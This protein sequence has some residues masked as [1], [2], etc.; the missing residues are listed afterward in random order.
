MHSNKRATV[1]RNVKEISQDD[2]QPKK[3]EEKLKKRVHSVSTPRPFFQQ[4]TTADIYSRQNSALKAPKKSTQSLKTNVSP[5]KDLQKTSPSVTQLKSNK[6][7][8]TPFKNKMDTRTPRNLKSVSNVTVNSPIV[9]RKLTTDYV[10]TPRT[11]KEV[12]NK[13][14]L[15]KVSKSREVLKREVNTKKAER[16]RTHTR[17]LEEGEVKVLTPEN[18]DNNTGM[19]NLSK[20]LSAQ[21]KAFYVDLEGEKSKEQN[22]ETSDEDIS[23]EDDFESYE[24]DFDSYHSSG[25]SAEEQ[26]SEKE[27]I[28]KEENMLDSGT[29]EMRGRSATSAEP[30]KFILEDSDKKTSLTDEG[31][32]D[33]SSSSTVSSMK[34]VHVEVLERPLFIDFTKSKENRRKRR[35]F[36]KLKQRANDIL[37]MVTLHEMSFS[38]FEMKPI[39]YDLYM[40][41][42]GRSNYTQVVVQTFDDGITV[43]VQTEEIEYG[44]KWTQHPVEFSKETI[45]VTDASNSKHNDDIEQTINDVINFDNR[46]RYVR[47][48]DS[49]KTNPLRIY[50][51]QKDGAG[52]DRMLP[53]ETYLS[54]TKRTE[55]NAGKLRKF[56]KKVGHRISN[57][58]SENAGY[59]VTSLKATSKYPFSKEFLTISSKNVTNQE[60]NYLKHKKITGVV[61]SETKSSLVLT[62]HCKTGEKACILCLWDLNVAILKPV[63]KL[64]A[65]EV[66]ERGVF[67]GDVDG[68]FV[69]ALKD[70]TVHLWDL[71]EQPTVSDFDTREVPNENELNVSGLKDQNERSEQMLRACAFTS[72]ASNMNGVTDVDS[73]VG[74]EFVTGNTVTMENGNK[75]VGQICTLLKR[76]Y[77]I[78]YSIIQEK[79]KNITADLGKA[80]WSKMRLEKHQTVVLSDY[81]IPTSDITS[82]VNF[83]LDTAK[84]KLLL[85]RRVMDVRAFSRPK[86]AITVDKPSSVAS[87][88]RFA[89][90]SGWE[91]GIICNTLKIVNINGYNRYLIGKNCGEVLDCRKVG[92]TVRIVRLN[93]TGDSSAITVLEVSK[94]NPQY[95]LAGSNGGTVHL[96]SL[97]ERR[98]LLTLDCRNT[99]TVVT[100]KCQA[101]SKGRYLGSVAVKQSY[102]ENC[103]ETKLAVT[104]L[105]WCHSNPFN[106]VVGTNGRVNVWKLT[107]SDIRPYK[108][109]ENAATRIV[110]QERNMAFLNMEGDIEVYKIDTRTENSEVFQKYVS[111]L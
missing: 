87:L 1:T 3:Q 92:G 109:F 5:M 9:K 110:S 63:K 12:S 56:L 101:D 84:K 82:E 108:M 74:L 39:P 85:K 55:Y 29:F 27:K 73:I 66:V 76:G 20:K 70:G 26:E 107:H 61:F 13:E 93:I 15:S 69:A 40:A 103:F 65:T 67:R 8:P 35:V 37:S 100:E 28:Y 49:Y 36:E 41:T 44:S 111:I 31:F 47:T 43:E 24:S 11:S 46:L 32:Q 25:Q 94:D 91:T 30:M 45:Y 96:C 14:V 75:V 81:I 33:M 89:D 98:V 19:L 7:A 52:G 51:E 23:Y 10:N 77:L 106:I 97:Q 53:F 48:D 83:S 6:M 99:P 2:L 95:F 62:I 60:Q 50:L 79:N 80:F 105:A 59:F 38:L 4:S 71:S 18:V 21:A 54:K 72:S 17:T 42:F 78:T 16:P 34:T 57:A 88:K 64:I 22:K 86:S 68:F 102:D 90:I 58:L 104:S